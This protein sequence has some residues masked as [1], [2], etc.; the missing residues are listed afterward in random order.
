MQAKFC[1]YNLDKVLKFYDLNVNKY[2]TKY[3]FYKQIIYF[4]NTFMMSAFSM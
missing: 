1:V 3:F 2:K 4:R